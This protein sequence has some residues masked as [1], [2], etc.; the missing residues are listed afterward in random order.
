MSDAA[1][2]PV[3]VVVMTKNEEANIEK[4]LRSVAA[5]AEVFVVDSHSTDRTRE[6]AEAMGAQVVPFAWN[7]Q[8]PKKKQWCLDNLP[9]AHDW[10]FYVD[11]DEEATPELIAELRDLFARGPDKAGYTVAYRYWFLGRFLRHGHKIHKLVL[12]R[13][14][15][16]YFRRLDDLDLASKSEVELHYQPTIDGSVGRLD[17]EMLHRD[18]EDLFHFFERHNVY[19]DWEALLR[20]TGQRLGSEDTQTGARGLLKRAFQ[21]MPLRPLV[22]FVHSYVLLLGFL[23]GRPGFHFALAR[24]MYYWQIDAKAY[25]RRIGASRGAGQ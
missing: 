11:A 18:I 13:R 8:Y 16:G 23:D 25:E 15:K 14:G 4:C 6:L 7:G 24:A 3:S 2:L 19:S 21:R 22:A 10:V 17:A 20:T 9:F 5:C 12:F 1:K